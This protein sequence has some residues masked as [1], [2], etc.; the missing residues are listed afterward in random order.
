[1]KVHFVSIVMS[2]DPSLPQLTHL[3]RNRVSRLEFY[4]RKGCRRPKNT[5]GPQSGRGI[6][7]FPPDMTVVYGRT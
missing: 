3:F 2:T 1:L 5:N 4:K 6:E 7:D